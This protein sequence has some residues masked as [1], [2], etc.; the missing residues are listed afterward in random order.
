M[1]V[2]RTEKELSEIQPLRLITPVALAFIGD[3]VF[4]LYLRTHIVLEEHTAIKN[5]HLHASHYAKAETQSC[6]VRAIWDELSEEEQETVRRGRNAK[7]NT[8]PKHAQVVEYKMATGF[9]ALLGSLYLQK[10]EERLWEILN[11]GMK[12]VGGWRSTEDGKR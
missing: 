11:M 6:M 2:E 10:K 7:V 12:A 8:I 9:E 1:F 4:D 3:T 5:M